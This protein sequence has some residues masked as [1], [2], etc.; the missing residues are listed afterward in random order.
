[1]K[2]A[3]IWIKIHFFPVGLNKEYM[4]YRGAGVS[5]TG[6][7]SYAQMQAGQGTGGRGEVLE[8]TTVGRAHGS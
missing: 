5:C 1:M 8:P 7:T 2:P 4:E 3:G 6:T